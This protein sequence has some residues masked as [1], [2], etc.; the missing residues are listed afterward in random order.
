M[1]TFLEYYNNKRHS[2]TKELPIK[3]F[4]YDKIKNKEDIENIINNRNNKY[5]KS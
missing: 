4:Y 2:T 3:A 5:N 1:D